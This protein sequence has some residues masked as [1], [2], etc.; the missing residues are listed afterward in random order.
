MAPGLIDIHTHSDF[1]LPL[2]LRAESKIR[3]LRLM[4]AGME[5]RPV[6]REELAT[7]ERLLEEALAAGAW[8]LS[9]GTPA[10]CLGAG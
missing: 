8:G 4:T 7:M 3:T 10:R 6:R 2:N 5:S 9:S 1:T